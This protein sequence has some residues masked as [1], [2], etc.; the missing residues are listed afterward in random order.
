MP[1]GIVALL[2][3][4]LLASTSDAPAAADLATAYQQCTEA[5]HKTPLD[6]D[7]V[8]ARCEAPARQGVPGA[9]YVIGAM[10]AN[11]GKAN[12]LETAM[13]WLE[14][15]ANA[16][17]PAAAFHLASLLVTSKDPA[18]VERGRTLFRAAACAGAPQALDTLQKAGGTRESIGCAPAADTDFSGEWT[19][20]LKWQN[21]LPGSQTTQS[22]RVVIEGT[23]ARVYYKLK[24]A[25]VEAKPGK[26]V[27]TQQDQSAT[28]AVT[29]SGWDFD[30][31]WIETWTMQLMRTGADEA[32]VAYL[33]TVNNPHLPPQL[34][35][36]TFSNFAQGTARRTKR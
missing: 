13:P 25:W 12:D 27:F 22:Y 16:G 2:A 18:Q 1:I 19:L 31:K 33:R 36:R 30:G 32:A 20:D 6:V 15:A 3:A 5:T 17:H 14:K 7:A 4:S 28:V 8:V 29:D 34:A 9:Q 26:F 24:D 10:L 11:R 35:W 21:P 23:A